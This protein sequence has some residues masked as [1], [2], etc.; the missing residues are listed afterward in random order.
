M[1]FTYIS[2]L[3]NDRVPPPSEETIVKLCEAMAAAPDELLIISR[4]VPR[5]VRNLITTSPGAFGFLR[6]A[7]NMDLTE[8]EWARMMRA[9]KRVKKLAR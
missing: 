9:L 4:K 3:E 1:D 7:K 2:K 8:E 5:D 6:E